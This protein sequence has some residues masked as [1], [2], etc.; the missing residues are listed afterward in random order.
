M[1]KVRSSFLTILGTREFCEEI[2]VI[3]CHQPIHGFLK[4]SSVNLAPP[5]FTSFGVQMG[6]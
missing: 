6:T 4:K 2:F 1:K 5:I 3:I